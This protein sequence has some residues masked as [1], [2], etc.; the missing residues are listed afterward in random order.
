MSSIRRRSAA[1]GRSATPR[2]AGR[3]ATRIAGDR[4]ARDSY[5]PA[6]VQLAGILRSRIVSG[7]FQAGD[8]LPTETELV[9]AFGLSPMTVRRAIKILLDERAVSTVPG[10]GT[11][12]EAASIQAAAFDLSS[13]HALLADPD[14][15]VRILATSRV[16]ASGRPAAM[17]GVAQGT[18]VTMIRRLLLRGTVPRLYHRQWR[19]AEPGDPDVDA[20]LG[21]TGLRDLFEG[22]VG[23]GPKRGRLALYASALRGEE[24]RQLRSEPGHPAFVLEHLFF[25]FD[26]KPLSWGLFVSRGEDLHFETTIGFDQAPGGPANET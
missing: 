18:P 3:A 14:I 21:V 16:P 26:D 5:E 19:I 15:N 17:L 13:F 20:E 8:R 23:V 11:F 9:E 4:I 24:A 2:A 6:Y 10:R 1:P 25:G 7:E 12:V 22:R